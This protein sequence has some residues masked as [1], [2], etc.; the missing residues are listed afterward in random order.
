MDL[1][2]KWLPFDT[3]SL[4]GAADCNTLLGL[5]GP[6]GAGHAVKGV[7]NTL[8]A[9]HIVAASEGLIALVKQGVPVEAAL[10][11][12]NGSSG[13]SL[14][15]EERIPN[16]VLSGKF[17]FGFKL[18]LMRKDIDVCM[19]Q[20]DTADVHAPLLRQVAQIFADAEAELGGGGGGGGDPQADDVEHM[21]VIR[22]WEATNGVVLRR[23]CGPPTAS[24]DGGGD[25]EA[26]EEAEPEHRQAETTTLDTGSG[27]PPSSS[28]SSDPDFRVW[29][30][31]AGPACLPTDVL[32]QVREETLNWNQHGMP[33]TLVHP[34]DRCRVP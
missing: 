20:L 12:I 25:G 18:E 22:A 8:L 34:P 15:T 30:F 3:P 5:A 24:D 32:K 6:V 7:N 33:R 9:S 21:E 14:V 19:R 11:A 23:D 16:H 26:K 31:S 28:D 29:N 1:P 13:R 2:P 17:D 10:D 4:F 27:D